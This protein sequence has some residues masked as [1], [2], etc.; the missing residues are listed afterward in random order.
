MSK[1]ARGYSKYS[2]H[3]EIILDQVVSRRSRL[4]QLSFATDVDIMGRFLP[5]TRV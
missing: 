1:V 3:E 4:D 2:M 5:G